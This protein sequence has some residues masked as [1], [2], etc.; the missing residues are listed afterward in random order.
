MKD[1]TVLQIRK[2]KNTLIFHQTKR[3]GWFVILPEQ[4]TF[5][6][7]I[8]SLSGILKYSIQAGLLSKKVLEGILSELQE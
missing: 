7:D 5:A 8:E 6:I 1:I 2:I 4:E 3:G